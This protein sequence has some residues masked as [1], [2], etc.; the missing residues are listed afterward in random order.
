MDSVP[1]L[2]VVVPC[3][4]EERTLAKSINRVLQIADNSLSLEIIIVD[5]GSKDGSLAIAN[6][7]QKQH[8]ETIVLLRHDK[9]QGK[10]ASL[11]TG[12][13]KATGDFVAIQDADLEY[14]PQDLRKLIVPL[15][16]NDAD[17][18]LGSRFL[19]YG[20]HRVIYFW[21]YVGNSILTL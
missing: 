20:A 11:R 1:K 6:S 9:N 8:P 15:I 2:S 3:Y 13:K 17:V 19:S 7:L 21:H 12:F 18:V 14:N 5:D 10:G 4:N 16:E